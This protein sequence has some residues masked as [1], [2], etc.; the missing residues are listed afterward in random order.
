MSLKKMWESASQ[1]WRGRKI[2]VESSDN[3]EASDTSVVFE[4]APDDPS[5]SLFADCLGASSSTVAEVEQTDE[6]AEGASDV[7]VPSDATEEHESFALLGSMTQAPPFEPPST[8]VEEKL[9]AVE[10]EEHDTFATLSMVMEKRVRMET[11]FFKTFTDREPRVESTSSRSPRLH[12]R[13]EPKN[14][15]EDPGLLTIMKMIADPEG[16]EG[17]TLSS[18]QPLKIPTPTTKQNSSNVLDAPWLRDE[19]RQLV[20]AAKISPFGGRGEP[21]ATAP[22]EFHFVGDDGLNFDALSSAFGA[23]NKS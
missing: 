23:D 10:N 20:K 3:L 7:S 2:Q 5:F 4:Q 16:E 12:S 9:P 6:S 11:Q 21:D 22:G 17:T 19:K 14:E 1:L 18:G 8:R 13:I 15:A